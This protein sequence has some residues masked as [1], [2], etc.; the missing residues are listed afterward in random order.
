MGNS[1]IVHLAGKTDHPVF[2]GLGPL[3]AAVGSGHIG[4]TIRNRT[5]IFITLCHHH[6]HR[7]TPRCA[8]FL[9]WVEKVPY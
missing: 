3:A 8:R 4:L 2:A 1:P 7:P 9:I 6:R 5:G